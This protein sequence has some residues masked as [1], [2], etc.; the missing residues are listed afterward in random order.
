MGNLRYLKNV[1]TLQL[2]TEKCTGCGRCTEVC[3]HGVFIVKKG[4][5]KIIDSD[6]C[7]ECGACSKNCSYD[8]ISVKSGVACATGI[9]FGALQ[10]NKS[11]CECAKDTSC[12]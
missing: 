5:A 9:I 3:P 12:C 6:A 11:T 4:K 1:T 2:D 8:A 7:M 10:K